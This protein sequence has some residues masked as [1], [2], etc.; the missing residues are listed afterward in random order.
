VIFSIAGIF[1]GI[2]CALTFYKPQ[3]DKNI[4]CI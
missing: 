3:N 4:N 2:M 1:I